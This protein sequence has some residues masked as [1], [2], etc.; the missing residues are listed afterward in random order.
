MALPRGHYHY[1]VKGRAIISTDVAEI[2]FTGRT[3]GLR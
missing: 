2:F 3:A 1:T